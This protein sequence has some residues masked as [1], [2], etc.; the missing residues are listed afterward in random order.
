MRKQTTEVGDIWVEARDGGNA[1]SFRFTYAGFEELVHQARRQ[2]DYDS[3]SQQEVLVSGCD[4][5][6]HKHID[7]DGSEHM[8]VLEGLPGKGAQ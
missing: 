8:Y 1:D 2:S 3:E 6:S 4:F 5:G 7:D